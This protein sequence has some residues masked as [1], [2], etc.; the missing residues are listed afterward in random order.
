MRELEAFAGA[1]TGAAVPR[2]KAHG[3][4]GRR[5]YPTAD[6]A[7]GAVLEGLARETGEPHTVAGA[8]T[9]HGPDG[10]ETARVYRLEPPAGAKGKTYRPVC[11]V[12]DGWRLGDPAGLWPL[13]GLAA[14]AARPGD[15]VYLPEG[16]KCAEALAGLGLL[17]VASA[18]GAGA[19]HKTDWQPLAGRTVY[20][21]P[22]NDTPGRGY[23]S[24]VTGCM[25]ALSPPARV[26]VVTL[27]GVAEHGDVCDYSEALRGEGHGPEAIRQ[28]LETMAQAAAEAR[29]LL[30]GGNAGPALCTVRAPDPD[31][32]DEPNPLCTDSIEPVP[33]PWEALPAVFR[34]MGQA[35][36]ECYGVPE[37]MAA[38]SVL[39]VASVALGNRARLTIKAPD[40]T[41]YGNLF[42]MVAAPVGMGKTPVMKAILAPLAEMQRERHGEWKKAHAEWEDRERITMA[43]VR[44][45]ERTVEREPDGGDRAGVVKSVSALRAGL[46]ERPAEPVLFCDDTTSEALAQRIMGNGGSVG[47]VS[48]EA[49][50]VLEIARGRYSQGGDISLWLAGH[51]CDRIRVD[52]T[53]RPAYEIDEPCLSSLIMTQPDSLPTLAGFSAMR[54]SGFL[55][56]W[57]YVIPDTQAVEYSTKTIPPLTAK[58]YGDAIRA[59]V[60]LPARSGVLLGPVAVGLSPKAFNTWRLFHDR[61]RSRSVSTF[62]RGQELHGHWLAKLPEHAARLALVLH[63]CEHAG[64][65]QIPAEVG[66]DTVDAAIRLAECL[67]GHARRAF[68]AMTGRRGNATARKVWQWIDRNRERLAGWREREGLGLVEAVKA[69]DVA[70]N[71]IAGVKVTRDATAVLD[72]LAEEGWL[73]P[74]TEHKSAHTCKPH[75]FYFIRPPKTAQEGE[76]EPWK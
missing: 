22:D 11:R 38:A 67:D 64:K 2:A 57:L 3:L 50:K 28:T 40:H 65:A 76:A 30:P 73:S 63:A 44:G 58:R 15:P 49:R 51:G 47:V 53:G 75:V 27:P 70:M 69:R 29:P 61:T 46:G 5:V 55:A 20:V 24:D 25:A 9:Y 60:A 37:V 31:E 16:E 7:A 62:D 32:W 14:L 21:F 35:L 48:S 56:R 8:W 4:N 74:V 18:H 59:L 39:G 66:T 52:R 54:E 13:Y 45:L 71:D 12:P 41:Q 34:D 23:A 17:A 33:C 43:Q 72:F 42:I 36:A 1:A 26:A 10:Q 19:A 68:A 6:A